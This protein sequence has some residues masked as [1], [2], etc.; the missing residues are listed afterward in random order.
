MELSLSMRGI[1][2]N[3][4]SFPIISTSHTSKG[5]SHVHTCMCAHTHT[6]TQIKCY[7][8][9]ENYCSYYSIF[10]IITFIFIV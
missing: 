3:L 8:T 4:K 10:F 9:V 1:C 7:T 6:N 2:A 5:D